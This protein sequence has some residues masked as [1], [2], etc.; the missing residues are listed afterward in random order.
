M[1]RAHSVPLPSLHHPSPARPPNNTHF[2]TLVP[3]ANTLQGRRGYYPGALVARVLV[4]RFHALR[5]RYFKPSNKPG[6]A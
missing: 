5:K 1:V 3:P 2:D 6:A 4:N